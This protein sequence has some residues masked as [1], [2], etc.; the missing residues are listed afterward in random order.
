M[1]TDT[2]QIDYLQWLRTGMERGWVS[3]PWCHSHDEPPMT[4]EE[5]EAVGEGFDVCVFALR[6]W[7]HD[8][9]ITDD[10]ETP[11]NVVSLFRATS[12]PDE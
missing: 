5:G 12:V 6:V 10:E 1:D 11:T 2:D 9:V 4:P 7:A 8:P 3:E